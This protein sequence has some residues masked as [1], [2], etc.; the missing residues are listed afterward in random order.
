VKRLRTG[1]VQSIGRCCRHSGDGDSC[2]LKFPMTDQQR[3]KVIFHPDAVSW[4]DELAQEILNS[5]GSFGRVEPNPRGPNEIHPVIEIPASDIIGE[6]K[7]EQ[8]AV[9]RLGEEMGRYWDSKGLRVG[10]E[11]EKFEQIKEHARR[12]EMA[13][14]IKGHVSEAFPHDEVFNWLRGTLELQ[15]SDSLSDYIAERC[16]DAIEEHEI[17]IPVHR[18][19]SAHN[20]ALGDG[21]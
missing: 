21:L 10:W 13:S 8:S 4:F 5:V 6:V 2:E 11:G 12:F 18:T 15:R 1:F 3:S 14:P 19:Y 7:V 16:S 17:W 20:F 9:N